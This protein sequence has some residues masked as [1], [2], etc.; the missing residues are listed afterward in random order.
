MCVFKISDILRTNYKSFNSFDIIQP[1]V[2][3]SGMAAGG[4][5]GGQPVIQP[6]GQLGG[7]N[8]DWNNRQYI[9]LLESL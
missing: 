7:Q 6:G 9:K 8:S 1:G 4:H 5:P 3:Q 2:Q